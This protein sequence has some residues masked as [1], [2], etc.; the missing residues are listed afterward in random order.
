M[1]RG[2]HLEYSIHG[3]GLGSILLRHWIKKVSGYSVHMIPDSW[4]IQNFPL[5][6]ADSKS[7]GF[8]C[9]IHPIRVD[10]ALVDQIK[11]AFYWDVKIIYISHESTNWQHYFYVAYW[12]WDCHFTRSSEPREGRQALCKAKA[13]SSSP[14][15]PD[16]SL[17]L[18]NQALYRLSELLVSLSI[19][20]TATSTRAE[21]EQ[22]VKGLFAWRR[23]IR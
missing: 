8:V 21:K 14:I 11:K 19:K 9:R 22:K 12:I 20:T 3:K 18:C 4:R 13:V 23:G 15:E 16:L 17:S 1:R 6:R 2:R 7:Y 5:W 10:E